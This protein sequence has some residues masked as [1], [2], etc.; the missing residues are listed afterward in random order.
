MTR[1]ILLLA[2]AL[3]AAS[4]AL[5]RP[6]PCSA[7]II[8]ELPGGREQRIGC[9]WQNGRALPD[10]LIFALPGSRGAPESDQRAPNQERYSVFNNGAGEGPLDWAGKEYR[11]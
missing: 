4:P 10:R 11:R 9:A 2:A 7:T 6:I 1:T 3:L 8:E 5:A